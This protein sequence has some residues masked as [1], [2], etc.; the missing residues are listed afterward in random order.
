LR[1]PVQRHG[2]SGSAPANNVDT[3]LVNGKALLGFRV[4]VIIASSL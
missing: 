3:D 4:P 2:C 1:D